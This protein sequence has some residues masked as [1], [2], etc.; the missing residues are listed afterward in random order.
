MPDIA[1]ERTP[2]HVFHGLVTE[3]GMLI[4]QK[5]QLEGIVG[6]RR[7]DDILFALAFCW[8]FEMG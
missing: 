3:M 8:C 2:V 4:D 7:D 1:K 5:I 6:V